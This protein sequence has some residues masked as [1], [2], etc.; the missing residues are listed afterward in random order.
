[1]IK[2]R[3]A[4]AMCENIDWNVGRVLARLNELKLAENTIVLYFSDNGPNGARWNGGMKGQKGSTDE[5]GV[6]SPLL[7]RWPA[8]IKPGIRVTEIA[9]AIDLLPTVAA[10]AGVSIAGDRPLD[11]LSLAPLLMG[12]ATDWP[13]RTLVN[14]WNG[15][16]SLRTPQFRLDNSGALFDMVA[17]PEQRRDIAKERPQVAATLQKELD[18]RRK[19]IRQSLGKDDRPFTVGFSKST[20]LPARDGVPHGNV[21]RSGRAPNCSYFTN[22]TSPRDRITWDVEIGQPGRYEAVVH[23][24]CPAADVGS[25]VEVSLGDSRV[26]GKVGK[27]HDPP[28]YGLAH[29]RT[30]RGGESYM[31][32]FEPLKL[33]EFDLAAGRGTLTL[34][35]LEVPGKQVMEVRYVVLTRVP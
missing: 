32:D 2:T 24:T 26:T 23:Y 13:E 15:R 35:A 19:E 4:L 8:K 17:D 34:R 9:Q 33:G 27:A 3:A 18:Q 28:P 21:E 20:P 6:R 10:L 25:V 30:D 1:V 14:H 7:V 11:G 16:V 31:K 29:D 12:T 22:W 5:G